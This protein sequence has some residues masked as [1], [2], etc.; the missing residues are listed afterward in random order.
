MFWSSFFLLDIAEAQKFLKVF[1]NSK[2]GNLFA[3]I[4]WFGD[5]IKKRAW[6][7]IFNYFEKSKVFYITVSVEGTPR[8][9]FGGIF[10]CCTLDTNSYQVYSKTVLHHFDYFMKRTVSCLIINYVSVI[11]SLCYQ[12]YKLCWTKIDVKLHDISQENQNFIVFIKRSW[13]SN[14][15]PKILRCLWEHVHMS[16]CWLKY[17]KGNFYVYVYMY[18]CWKGIMKPAFLKQD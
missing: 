5:Y 2:L 7:L 9:I 11:T 14:L 13:K 1:T 18:L 17:I 12:S 15:V 4:I 8:L 6:R 3:I 16:E 10:F